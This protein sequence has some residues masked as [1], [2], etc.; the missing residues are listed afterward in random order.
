MLTTPTIALLVAFSGPMHAGPGLATSDSSSAQLHLVRAD[1][2]TLVTPNAPDAGRAGQVYQLPQG[3]LGV[4]TGGTSHY[5]T[6]TMPGGGSGIAVPGSN[7]MSSVIG[8][9]GRIGTSPGTY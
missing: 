9:G 6:L 7:G 3:G 5:Q 8:S 2:H 4:T 1:Y